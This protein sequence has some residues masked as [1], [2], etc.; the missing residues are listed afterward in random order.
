MG[1]YKL[2][3]GS[4]GTHNG[5]YPPPNLNHDVTFVDDVTKV[6][7]MSDYMLFNVKG[8]NKNSC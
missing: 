4:P 8:K 3:K 6:K 1:D 2:I 5:W 7:N